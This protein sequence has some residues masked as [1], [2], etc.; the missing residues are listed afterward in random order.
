MDVVS[1]CNRFS[2][3]AHT[4]SVTFSVA[5]GTADEQFWV[6]KPIAAV[7]LGW[8]MCNLS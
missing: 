5:A 4:E 6:A 7:T 3:W 1:P 8:I 2:W